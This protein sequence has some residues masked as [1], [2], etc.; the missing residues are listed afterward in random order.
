MPEPRREALK[1]IGAIGSTCAFPFAADELYAQHE[2][3]ASN[4]SAALP[5]KPVFFNEAEFA[6]ISRMADLI[7]P[8]TD[9]PGAL[10]AGVP[11]Y[12]DMVVSNNKHA[13][14]QC[15][16]GIAWLD[17]QC[18][19]KHGKRFVDLAADQQVAILT[20]LCA[21]ADKMREPPPGS[22]LKKQ[23]KPKLGPA[24]FRTVKSLTADGFFT[25]KAGLVDALGYK[26]NTVLAEF[27]SCTHEH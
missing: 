3:S 7:I 16:A 19:K 25:S 18:Q 26:G 12:I 21:E 9:T 24:F 6:T 4:Q 2:H 8:A 14:Q 17:S 22:G 5:A 20:P 11:A 10:D 15:R 13:Q 1:I 27:P 23:P